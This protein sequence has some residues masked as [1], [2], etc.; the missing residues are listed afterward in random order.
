MMHGTLSN[1]LRSHSF[2]VRDQ[3]AT[4]VFSIL[5][6]FQERIRPEFSFAELGLE[7]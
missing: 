1:E 2:E 3:G 5:R 6:F 7:H 4:S